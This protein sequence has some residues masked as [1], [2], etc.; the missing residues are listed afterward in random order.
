MW[1]RALAYAWAG[2]DS[3]ASSRD[4]S[5]SVLLF[6]ESSSVSASSGWGLPLGVVQVAVVVDPELLVDPADAPDN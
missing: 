1:W 5:E 3:G 2:A 6:D 4:A